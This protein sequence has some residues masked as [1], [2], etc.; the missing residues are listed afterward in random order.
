MKGMMILGLV[1]G[2]IASGLWTVSVVCA[3]TW[4]NW[5]YPRDYEYSLRL[6]DDASLPADKAMYLRDYLAKVKTVKGPPRL[7]FKRPDLDLD[8]QVTI[9]EGLIKRF[10]DIAVIAPSEMAYQQGMYQLTGQEMDAQLDRIS[11]IFCSAK[12]RETPL[13]AIFCWWGWL[14]FLALA[15]LFFVLSWVAYDNM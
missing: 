2:I 3:I 9:L 11:K 4:Y 12:I 6:A 15:V 10:D 7:V 1:L 5:I 14:I 8:K 13:F